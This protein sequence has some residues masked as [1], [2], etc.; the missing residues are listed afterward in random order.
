[1]LHHLSFGVSDIGRAATFYDAA[2]SVLG[3]VRVWSDIREGESGQAVGY[4]YPGGGDKFALKQYDDC[5]APGPGF[6]VAFAAP[7]REAVNA[8]HKAAVLAGGTDNGAPGLRATMA[9]TIMPHSSS[10][11]TATA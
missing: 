10:I 2:L 8:F 3:Y 5:H 9:P 4:G 11:L 1:M 7:N 6:H